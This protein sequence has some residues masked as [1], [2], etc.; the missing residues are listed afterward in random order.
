MQT[1][2][3]MEHLHPVTQIQTTSLQGLLVKHS[4]EN[5]RPTSLRNH[6]WCSDRMPL[7]L[8][9]S[10]HAPATGG[11]CRAVS[12]QEPQEGQGGEPS[13]ELIYQDEKSLQIKCKLTNGE[14]AVQAHCLHI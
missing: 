12:F 14:K 10:T 3:K 1:D 6:G 2:T 8:P 4:L 13:R 7:P 5:H 9:H 11:G